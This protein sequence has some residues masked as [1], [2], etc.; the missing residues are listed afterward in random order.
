V[1]AVSEHSE[2]P[3]HPLRHFAV[4]W[5]SQ[6]ATIALAYDISM[7]CLSLPPARSTPLY[8][9]SRCIHEVGKD[10]QVKVTYL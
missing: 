7:C 10:A 2:V 3:A 5:A 8:L 9:Q 1:R 4:N 6:I